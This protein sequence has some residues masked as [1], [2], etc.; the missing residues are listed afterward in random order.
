MSIYYYLLLSTKN[1]CPV[2]CC[3]NENWKCKS[4]FKRNINY[5]YV[6]KVCLFVFQTLNK[7]QGLRWIKDNRFPAFLQSDL[8]IEYRL[9]KILSQVSQID[10][11]IFI[12]R[13]F[14]AASCS[15]C[16]STTISLMSKIFLPLHGH[17]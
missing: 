7:E 8:Y 12:N 11:R 2:I 13:N 16:T 15:Q 6:I 3:S 5:E 14:S 17:I 9:A 10:W 4:L 1:G